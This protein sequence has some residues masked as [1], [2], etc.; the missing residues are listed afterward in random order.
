[1]LHNKPE[2]PFLAIVW[3]QNGNVGPLAVGKRAR[4]TG[5]AAQDRPNKCITSVL[6]RISNYEMT[7]NINNDRIM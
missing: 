6:E 7:R 1:M 2:L 3:A 5:R 4:K